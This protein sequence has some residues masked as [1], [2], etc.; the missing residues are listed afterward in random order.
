MQKY[1]TIEKLTEKLPGLDCGACGSP[2]C[3]ALAEDIV[4][5]K[6]LETDCPFLL[7]EQL[8]EKARE[9]QE[10]AS[11]VPQTMAGKKED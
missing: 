5:G 4:L 9:I 1:Q 7:R 8:L 6:A 2:T 11:R 3:R 10:L